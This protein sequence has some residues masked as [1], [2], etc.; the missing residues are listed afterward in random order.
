MG[1]ADNLKDGVVVSTNWPFLESMKMNHVA[2][3]ANLGPVT[4]PDK[5][6]DGEQFVPWFW[7]DAELSEAVNIR[8]AAYINNPDRVLATADDDP[9][10]RAATQQL[11]WHQAN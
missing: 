3:A 11:L 1:R 7:P 6:V 5:I 2:P 4:H 9:I 8:Q 10:V